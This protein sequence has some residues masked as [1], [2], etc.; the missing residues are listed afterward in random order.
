ML[1]TRAEDPDLRPLR[2]AQRGVATEALRVR[3]DDVQGVADLVGNMSQKLALGLVRA[4]SFLLGRMELARSCRDRPLELVAVG[5]QL[6]HVLQL[7]D[8][9]PGAPELV[10]DDRHG[11]QLPAGVAV[12]AKKALIT[13]VCR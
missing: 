4:L 11:Q 9:L 6:G 8:D 12:S 1:A 3:Q 2:L 5:A 7:R 10:G 13:T